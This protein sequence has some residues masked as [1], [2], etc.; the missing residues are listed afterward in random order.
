MIWYG[1]EDFQWWNLSGFTNPSK[2]SLQAVSSAEISFR[3]LKA[4][5]ISAWMVQLVL[6]QT[7]CRHLITL[8][9]LFRIFCMVHNMS[10]FRFHSLSVMK[11]QQK[12][13]VS[14]VSLFLWNK[15]QKSL[16]WKLQNHLNPQGFCSWCQHFKP[17]FIFGFSAWRFKAS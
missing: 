4:C 6:Q 5:K 10:E 8:C 14:P 17:C 2:W 12:Y 1:M 11:F 15:K 13:P 9:F 7:A 16:Q 3:W